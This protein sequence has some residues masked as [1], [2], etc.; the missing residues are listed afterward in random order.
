MIRT[1]V[2]LVT[3]AVL[4]AIISLTSIVICALK[5]PTKYTKANV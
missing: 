1:S 4:S 3:N 2:E 5:V